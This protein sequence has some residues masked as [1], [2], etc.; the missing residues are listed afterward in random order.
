M[1]RLR[2]VYL[3]LPLMLFVGG[4]GNIEDETKY[5]KGFLKGTGA[6]RKAS[7]K[8]TEIQEKDH[9]LSSSQKEYKEAVMEFR[10]V[11]KEFKDLVPDKKYETQHKNLIKAMEEYELSTSKLLTGMSDTEGT[12]WK[13][14]IN[15][16]N[17]ATNMYVIAAGN[18]VDIQYG[19]KVGTTEKSIG[20]ISEEDA[21]VEVE[22]ETETA[23]TQPSEQELDLATKDTQTQPIEQNAEEK[24][25]AADKES[26]VE[27]S[28]Q[29]LT[30]DN[31]KEIIEYYSIGENDKLNDVAVENGEIKATIVLASNNLFPAKDMA[32]NRYSQLSDE[33]LKHEGWQTLTVTYANIGSISMT[34]NEKE[35]NE[36][37]DYFPV[38]KIEERLK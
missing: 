5:E 3:L 33:L 6:M 28:P 21:P 34:R 13:D 26:V 27:Q 1:L 30:V 20:K 4:C 38:L 25:P 14:G 36:I 32:V 24:V 19:N 11:T 29:Q 22:A 2:L 16:F 31:V 7:N 17:K 35:T 10:K 37:G 23:Q 18:I 8:M 12:E 15:Q 9:S